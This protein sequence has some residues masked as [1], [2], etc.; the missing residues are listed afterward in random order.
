MK[1]SNACRQEHTTAASENLHLDFRHVNG[2]FANSYSHP[3]A[4]SEILYA[5]F[6]HVNDLFG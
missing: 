6:R 3:T 5:D 1:S 2:L 4:A